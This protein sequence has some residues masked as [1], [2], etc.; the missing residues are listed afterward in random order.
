MDVG[1]AAFTT[2]QADAMLQTLPLLQHLVFHAGRGMHAGGVML[3]ESIPLLITREEILWSLPI[4]RPK[5][6]HTI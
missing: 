3:I 4:F 5:H 1:V 2:A 6:S